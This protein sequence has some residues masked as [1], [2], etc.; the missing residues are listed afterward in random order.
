MA[1]DDSESAGGEVVSARDPD[2]LR[3][4][5]ALLVELSRFRKCG[6]GGF[7][8]APDR[9]RAFAWPVRLFSLL[10]IGTA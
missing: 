4:W 9:E 10:K 6:R 2:D 8:R 7:F 3:S 1:Q 5:A